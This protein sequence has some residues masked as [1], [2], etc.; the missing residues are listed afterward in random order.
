TSPVMAADPP[1][2]V[3]PMLS[4]ADRAFI[5]SLAAPVQTPTSPV[6]LAKLPGPGTKSL[7]SAT[8]NCAS[9]T[10]YCEDNTNP[11]N[12]TGVDRNCAVG[13]PGHVTCDGV[14][15]WCP[16][17]CPCTCEQLETWCSQECYPCSYN[18]NCTDP[19]N[20]DSFCHCNFS[21][22]PP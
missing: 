14:T 19:D 9:G 10:V 5:A 7:C 12:C 18:F 16:T 2:R 21:T 1:P 15:T 20:C 6:L 8:A 4:A 13:E 22:C 11:A 17:G 3:A